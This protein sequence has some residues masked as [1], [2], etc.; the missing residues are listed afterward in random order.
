MAAYVE[1]Y[2]DHNSSSGRHGTASFHCSKSESLSS[3]DFF[4]ML[5]LA[6]AAAAL[7]VL[8]APDV[9]IGEESESDDSLSLDSE[10][11]FALPLAGFF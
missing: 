4:E 2:C 7:G 5:S 3:F 6:L 1:F 11:C 8:G 9:T 10:P